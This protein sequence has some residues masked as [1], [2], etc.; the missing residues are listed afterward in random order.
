[1]LQAED[2]IFLKKETLAHV[3]SCEFSEIF[4]NIFFREHL[5]ATTSENLWNTP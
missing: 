5:R 2:N 1:M 4:K 3:L